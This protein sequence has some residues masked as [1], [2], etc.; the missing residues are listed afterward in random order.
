[1]AASRFRTAIYKAYIFAGS[2]YLPAGSRGSM[3]KVSQFDHGRS[4]QLNCRDP[5]IVPEAS[6]L[7]S[8]ASL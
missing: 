5:E 4:L 2:D 1:M 8:I 3:R 7:L 6:E